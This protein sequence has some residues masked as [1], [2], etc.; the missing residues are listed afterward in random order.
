MS[1][2]FAYHKALYDE[3]DNPIDYIFLEVNSNFEKMTGLKNKDIIGEK[4]T[5]VLPGIEDDPANWIGRYG[6]VARTRKQMEFEDYS[7]PLQR[8]YYVTAYSPLKGF[9]ACI[10]LDITTRKKAEEALR[11]SKKRYKEL[12]ERAPYPIVILN[13]QGK[14][15]NVNK[16][17]L[18]LLLMKKK[19]LIGNFI[20]K[21][22]IYPNKTQLNELQEK[23]KE[24]ISGGSPESI[25][26]QIQR[27]NGSI[28]WVKTRS[29]NYTYND[30]Q[31][32]QT[33]IN[34]ITEIKKAEKLKDDINLKLEKKVRKRTY[35]LQNALREKNLL[36]EKVTR[37]SQ[38]KSKFMAEMSHELRTPLNSII[39]FT[40]LLLEGNYGDFDKSQ[41]D[42]LKNIKSSGEHLLKLINSIMDISK[43]ELGEM[44]LKLSKFSIRSILSN[45][46]TEFKPLLNK[47]NLK[48]KI[49]NLK[50]DFKILADPIKIKSILYN[51][52]SNAVKFTL[53]GRIDIFFNESKEFWEIKIKD[54]GIGIAEENFDALFQEFKTI[55]NPYI[56]N[57]EGSGLG[58][59]ITKK[60][61][62][63]LGGKINFESKEGKGTTFIITIPKKIQDQKKMKI[64]YFLDL[65]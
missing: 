56:T 13:N 36:L 5:D 30:S 10:F 61:V 55:E 9:F 43:I 34:D 47:K 18:D 26:F 28:R 44:E 17:L 15:L 7:E 32:I 23:Y 24:L 6:E 46:I 39:G 11:D 37:A 59:P 62:N 3:N 12:M 20:F 65:L 22:D 35:E 51:L 8:W 29:T 64:Q 50:K 60:L 38:F 45:I 63:T 49:H 19:D 21:L 58:L 52:I 16:K 40:E 1:A 2:A 41:L 53:E 25:E 48:I 54:T 31:F 42:F 33:I 14:I 4:V 57:E 27:S